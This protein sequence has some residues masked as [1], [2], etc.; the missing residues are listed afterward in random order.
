MNS[1]QNFKVFLLLIT[2]LI[3]LPACNNNQTINSSVVR[4]EMENRKIKRITNATIMEYAQN[5]GT[6]LSKMLDS[7][8]LVGLK[9]PGT[10]SCRPAFNSFAQVL[11]KEMG[12]YVSRLALRSAKLPANPKEAGIVEAFRYS[13]LSGAKVSDNL[14][15]LSDT[16][17]LYNTNIIVQNACLVCHGDVKKVKGLITNI[18]ADTLIGFA[19]NKPI[20]IYSISLRKDYLI[21]HIQVKY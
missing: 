3:W 17:I 18:S 5:R 19:V 13:T 10:T 2:T 20:G 12:A 11:D 21:K 15:P 1:N 8:I 14:Q 16:A 7:A 4:E 9:E 6:L